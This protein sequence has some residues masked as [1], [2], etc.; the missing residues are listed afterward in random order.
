MPGS[1]KESSCTAADPGLIPGL[2]R[3]AGEGVKE[4]EPQ[5]SVSHTQNNTPWYSWSGSEG[6]ESALNV[7]YPALIPGSGRS[8][9]E[10]NGN[11]LSTVFLPGESHGQEQ[12]C[13]LQALGSQRVGHDWATFTFGSLGGTQPHTPTSSFPWD[14]DCT[15]CSL[16][17]QLKMLPQTNRQMSAFVKPATV[18]KQQENI[19]V[20]SEKG[21][22][23]GIHHRPADIS[24]LQLV[25]VTKPCWAVNQVSCLSLP[26]SCAS[27][28]WTSLWPR[29]FFVISFL[30]W[31]SALLLGLN[32]QTVTSEVGISLEWHFPEKL[33]SF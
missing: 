3:S 25:V 24:H 14:T 19:N 20:Y 1:G 4:S 26:G 5:C 7:G 22:A 15:E 18:E 12:P 16:F 28:F 31:L 29:G 6:K 2:G 27:A 11:P 9:R 32:L 13:G 10:E 8:P 21:G 33:G 23:W 17:C 30:L